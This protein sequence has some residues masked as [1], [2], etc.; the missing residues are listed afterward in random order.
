MNALKLQ[1]CI[2]RVIL[3]SSSDLTKH[4]THISIQQHRLDISRS[5]ESRLEPN[6]T[7]RLESYF[8]PAVQCHDEHVDNLY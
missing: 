8:R 5:A 7:L 2:N 3:I 4:L 6:N 1:A